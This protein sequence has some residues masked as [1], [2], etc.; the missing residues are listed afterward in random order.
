VARDDQP[1]GLEALHRPLHVPDVLLEDRED[2]LPIPGRQAL[3][4]R[5]DLRDTIVIFP[6]TCAVTLP[7]YCWKTV[8][9]PCQYPDGN[10]CQSR[11]GDV[12]FVTPFVTP[13]RYTTER[14]V[15]TPLTATVRQSRGRGRDVRRAHNRDL[16]CYGGT[17]LRRL[18]WV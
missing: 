9:T 6:V 5:R 17:F 8:K 11:G 14:T 2:P 4:V 1:P 12:T 10:C 13:S 15:K 3:S 18:W 16:W 7:M